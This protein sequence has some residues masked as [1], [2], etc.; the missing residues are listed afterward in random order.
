M[1]VV[2]CGAGPVGALAALYAARKGYEVEIYEMRGDVTAEDKEATRQLGKSINITM[3]D[4]G[5]EALEQS[6]DRGLV[7]DVVNGTIPVFAREVHGVSNLGHLTSTKIRYHVQ[8][9]PLRV[10]SRG[11]LRDI[12]LNRI[13]GMPNVKSYYNRKLVHA[14][15]DAKVAVFTDPRWKDAYAGQKHV[16]VAFDLLIGA[17]GAHSAVRHNLTRYINMDI[18]QR[19]LD[20]CWCE[21]LV[22]QTTEGRPKIALDTLHVWPQKDCMFLALPNPDGTFTCNLFAPA[23]IIRDLKRSGKGSAVVEFFCQKFPGIVPQLM[24]PNELLDQFC[25]TTPAELHDMR[26]SPISYKNRCILVGDAAHTMVPFYGQGMNTGLEDVRVLF[27]DYLSRIPDDHL[28]RGGLP[29]ELPLFSEYSAQRQP[30]VAVMTALALENYA[31]MRLA[32]K[33]WAKSARRWLEETLQARFP[34]LGWSTLYS[35]V[36]F[37]C[38]RFTEI[39]RKNEQQ[40]FV[41]KALLISFIIFF[42]T[43][44]A[45]M[46]SMVCRWEHLLPAPLPF[47]F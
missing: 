6:G 21:F 9:K 7:Q 19:W 40:T 11:G 17:D 23:A 34:G 4:R 41:L 26:V 18:S 31:E 46:F 8:D 24:T 3:S 12:L 38:E 35:R 47:S 20:L 13:L 29:D 16:C 36:A 25:R 15:L 28:S 14:D 44:C 42:F 1:K 39:Q 5:F 10:V 2:I 37:S 45:I 27:Q 43:L 33:S 22:S 32:Q 30:D